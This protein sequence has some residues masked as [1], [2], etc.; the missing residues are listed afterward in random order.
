[1]AIWLNG[2]DF[3]GPSIGHDPVS[4]HNAYRGQT[5]GLGKSWNVRASS[6]ERS[7]ADAV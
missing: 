6:Q 3:V 7:S 5:T 2:F 4:G 1:L